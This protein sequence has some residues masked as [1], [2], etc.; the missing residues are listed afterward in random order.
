MA[1]IF[2]G[3][4]PMYVFT[5]MLPLYHHVI[6]HCYLMVF[7]NGSELMEDVYAVFI[8]CLCCSVNL[9]FSDVENRIMVR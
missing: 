7:L 5:M 3:W 8:F 9:T 2:M 1:K 4:Q 6:F